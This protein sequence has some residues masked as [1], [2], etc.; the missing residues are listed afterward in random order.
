MIDA[1]R[2]CRQPGGR[3]VAQNEGVIDEPP[4]AYKP[5]EAVVAAQT[6]LVEIVHTPKQVV[7]VKG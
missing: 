5:I 4:R 6:D 1:R 7:C 2:A 3:R